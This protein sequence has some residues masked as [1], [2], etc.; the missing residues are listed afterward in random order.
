MKTEKD[1]PSDRPSRGGGTAERPEEGRC[2]CVADH[3]LLE[4][5]GPADG[6]RHG[7]LRSIYA[8][9]DITHL[10]SGLPQYSY[11]H[12]MGSIQDLLDRDLQ[13]EKDGFPRKIRIAR[14]IRPV[15]GGKDKVVVVPTTIEE[16]FYHDARIPEQ[17]ESNRS[18]GSG[19]GQEGEVVGEEPIH[20]EQG[21]GN[22]GP[23][24]GEGAQHEIQ[25]SLYDLGRILSNEF[26]LPNLKNKGKKRALKKY[27]Y[28]LTDLN[29]GSGQVLDK[30]ATLRRIIGTNIVLERVPDV[31][32][33]DPS[34]LLVSAQ[35]HVYRVFSKE[36]DYES[37]ALVFFMRDYS[38]SM[39]GEPTELIVAQHVMIYSWLLYQYE[40]LVETRFILHDTEAREV[41][42]FYTYHNLSI[43]GGTRIESAYRIINEIVE[44]SNLDRDYNIYVFQGTDGDDWDSNGEKTIPE[45]RKTL[46]YANRIGVTIA[47]G[48]SAESLTTT[49]E[50]Y[51]G[52][53]KAEFPDKLKI[54]VINGDAQ[55]ARLIEGMRHL[56]ALSEGKRTWS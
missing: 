5:P 53:L 44:A 9:A 4:A 51:L 48:Q 42:D 12:T 50:K 21:A 24:Q 1:E 41:P 14:L 7:F 38:G 33:I 31:T 18:G 32:A 20:R 23:G 55:E 46:Q 17:Q 8:T 54:D 26:R 25:A 30:K 56:I 40:G 47:C 10:Q 49:F 11:L 39:S 2:A 37:Q 3:V 13:R 35:D 34:Q 52:G 16:K 6:P 22:N 19:D 43:A 29:R 15:K 27:T 28:D 45:M 36:K